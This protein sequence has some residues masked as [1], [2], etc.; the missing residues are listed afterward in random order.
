MLGCNLKFDGSRLNVEGYMIKHLM[1]TVSVVGK[2]MF[3]H[4]YHLIKSNFSHFK[5]SKSLVTDTI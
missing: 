3:L 4:S 5:L 2:R 1:L